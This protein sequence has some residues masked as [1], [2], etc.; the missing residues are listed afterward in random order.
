MQCDDERGQSDGRMVG[1]VTNASFH[2]AD[3]VLNL[4]YLSGCPMV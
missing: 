3:A 1:R 4:D 2:K